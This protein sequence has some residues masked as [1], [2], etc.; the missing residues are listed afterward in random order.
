MNRNRVISLFVLAT[1]FVIALVVINH[2][3]AIADLPTSGTKD[4]ARQADAARWQVMGDYYSK[5]QASVS[6]IAPKQSWDAYAARLQGQADLYLQAKLRA[7]QA[8]AARWQA[9]GEYYSKLQ[10]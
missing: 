2:A 3:Y 5:Q 6:N 4:R 7:R 8:D 10:K 9:M 1:L